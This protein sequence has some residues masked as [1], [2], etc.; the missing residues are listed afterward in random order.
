MPDVFDFVQMPTAALGN[1]P[2]EHPISA[3]GAD[4]TRHGWR[5]SGQNL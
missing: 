4:L 2:L 3:S 5:G 1:T